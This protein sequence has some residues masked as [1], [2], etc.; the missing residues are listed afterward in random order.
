[1][2]TTASG[3]SVRI[4]SE[5]ITE[6]IRC[7]VASPDIE[8]P[9]LQDADAKLRNDVVIKTLDAVSSIFEIRVFGVTSGREIRLFSGSIAITLPYPDANQDGIIDGTDMSENNVRVVYLD[10]DTRQWVMLPNASIDKEKNNITVGVSRLSAFRIVYYAVENRLDN[11]IVY[12]NPC[13]R[14]RDGGITFAN[15]PQDADASITLYTIAGERVRTLSEG[16]E[17][18]PAV[19]AKRAWWDTANDYGNPVASGIYLYRI[20]TGIGSKTGKVAIVK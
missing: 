13:R 20:T 14:S 9:V 4:S 10:E 8:L 7:I 15:I 17:I 2:Y 3:V 11:I 16:K 1:M 18:L 19:G 12:P 6:A 5:T